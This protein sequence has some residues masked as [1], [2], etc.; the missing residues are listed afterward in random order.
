MTTRRRKKGCRFQS[1]PAITAQP[2]Y[3]FHFWYGDVSPCNSHSS[4]IVEGADR[5]HSNAYNFESIESTVNSEIRVSIY[6]WG[7]SLFIGTQF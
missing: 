4:S 3:R 6:T 2:S 5:P 1:I 7:S